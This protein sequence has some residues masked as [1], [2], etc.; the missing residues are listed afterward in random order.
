M[1]YIVILLLVLLIC[2]FII[3]CFSVKEKFDVINDK[4]IVSGANDGKSSYNDFNPNYGL[5]IDWN[6]QSTGEIDL[7]SNG[8][9]GPGGFNFYSTSAGNQGTNQLLKVDSAGNTTI[10]GNNNITNTLNVNGSTNINNIRQNGNYS[11]ASGTVFQLDAPNIPGGRLNIDTSGNVNI[12]NGLFVVDTA[13]NTT[14]QGNLTYGGTYTDS[15]NPNYATNYI[16][17]PIPVL[18]VGLEPPKPQT[19]EQKAVTQA[20]AQQIQSAIANI[21]F[22]SF[23]F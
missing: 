8:Q 11:M 7:I 9:G 2:Y 1:K 18:V 16:N 15:T 3:N 17:G 23:G 10:F 21:S 14:I 6:E 20:A 5:L 4:L 13:G 12:G 19:A 22:G